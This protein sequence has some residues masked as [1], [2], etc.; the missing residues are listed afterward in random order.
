MDENIANL[1]KIFSMCPRSVSNFK[2]NK[3]RDPTTTTHTHRSQDCEKQK[4]T[5][6]LQRNKRKM[7]HH[8]Q[9]TQAKRDEFSAEIMVAGGSAT[10][11]SKC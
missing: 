11:H 5:E 3:Q 8:V 6:N 10:T 4:S 2:Y 1:S 9:G 7:S